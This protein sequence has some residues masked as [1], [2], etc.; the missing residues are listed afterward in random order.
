MIKESFSVRFYIR[1]AQKE[2]GAAP[3][4]MKVWV[5]ATQRYLYASTTL[6]MTPSQLDA[7]ASDGTATAAADPDLAKAVRL[8]RTAAD[9][10]VTAAIS[11]N[12]IDTLSSELFAAKVEAVKVRLEANERSGVNQPVIVYATPEEVDVCA[13]C[14][15]RGKVCR[16]PWDGERSA[17]FAPEAAAFNN[18]CVNRAERLPY[19][20]HPIVWKPNPD[21][22]YIIVMP[23]NEATRIHAARIEEAAAAIIEE[24]GGN[25]E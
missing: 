1:K 13:A 6:L 22:D 11:H 16:A 25:N 2:K 18:L 19:G 10:V 3:L 7:F 14:V 21:P 24:E 8:Y 12:R 23:S 9:L 4:R 15:F 17:D 5:G 20:L